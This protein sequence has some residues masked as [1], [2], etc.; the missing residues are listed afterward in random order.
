MLNDV[1]VEVW[2]KSRPNFDTWGVE[3]WSKFGRSFECTSNHTLGMCIIVFMCSKCQVS[4]FGG[5]FDKTSTLEV[6]QFGRSL[7]EVWSK[8]GLIDDDRNNQQLVYLSK[9]HMFVCKNIIGHI[10]YVIQQH[11][12]FFRNKQRIVFFQQPFKQVVYFFG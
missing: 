3:V 9:Q 11:I 10:N 12:S 6:S 5:N 8:F 7:V 2:S 1:G 4:K